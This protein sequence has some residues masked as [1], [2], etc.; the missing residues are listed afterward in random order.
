MCF[1]IDITKGVKR[2]YIGRFSEYFWEIDAKLD[3]PW[4]KDLHLKKIIDII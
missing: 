1:E 4:A 3:M 2:S